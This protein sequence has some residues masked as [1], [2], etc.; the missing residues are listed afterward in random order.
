MNKK[1]S[2]A[3]YVFMMMSTSIL[4]FKTRAMQRP[5]TYNSGL[6]RQTVGK[7]RTQ[8]YQ[9]HTDDIASLT[10]PNWRGEVQF[11]LNRWSSL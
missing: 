8:Y 4:P 9:I 11:R 10:N 6:A 1:P 2:V 3:G 7:G 5:D